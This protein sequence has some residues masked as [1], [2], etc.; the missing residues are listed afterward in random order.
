MGLRRRPSNPTSPAMWTSPMTMG[1]F[2]MLGET[3][4]PKNC[5][6]AMQEEFGFVVQVIHGGEEPSFEGRD[7]KGLLMVE[8]IKH[9]TTKLSSK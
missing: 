5:S 2:D 8:A 7:K 3:V 1:R 9:C 4:Y 6:R